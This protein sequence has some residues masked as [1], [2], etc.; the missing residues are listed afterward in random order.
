MGFYRQEHWSG[1]PFPS[2]GDPPNPGIK[3]G[4]PALQVVALPAEPPGGMVPRE[5]FHDPGKPPP[6]H[7]HLG[8]GGLGSRLMSCPAAQQLNVK[9]L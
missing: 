9:A 5:G 6:P 3:P 8:E 4:A 2:P 1:L 7:M